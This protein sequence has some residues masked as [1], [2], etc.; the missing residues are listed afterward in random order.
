[1]TT[2]IHRVAALAFGTTILVAVLLHF[3]SG[4]YEFLPEETKSTRSNVVPPPTVIPTDQALQ[5]LRVTGATE[6]GNV[7]VQAL[8]LNL[9]QPTEEPILVF[10]IALN[11]HSVSLRNVD[12]A[13]QAHIENSEGMMIRSGFRWKPEHNEGYHHIMGYLI[14][15]EQE[16]TGSLI[17]E[18]VQWIKLVLQG[19]PKIERREFVWERTD[20]WG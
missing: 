2:Q 20:K 12:I 5:L 11:T 8:L 7:E 9:L 18:N 19:I 15:P 3:A 14:V 10:Q 6:P 17:G 13:K 4:D 16:S 1:M